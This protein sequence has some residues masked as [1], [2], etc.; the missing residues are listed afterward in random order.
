MRKVLMISVY[1][2]MFL[3]ANVLVSVFGPAITPI[4]ALFLIAG[5]MVLRDRIQ[6]ESGVA[7]S[8]SACVI[9]GLATIAIAPGS[10][11]IAV[12]SALSVMLA[13]SASALAFKLKS[14]GFF[15]KAMPANI[16]AAAVDSL[17]FPLI[18]FGSIMPGV[19]LAQFAAKTIGATIILMI[20][21]R[22]TKR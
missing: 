20:I 19:T 8:I 21:K 3:I 2:T 15:S 6:Y 17:A 1:V 16:S 5:D 18:A 12:A 4:N 22:Y 11:M 14:G 7:W 13:G 10:E 9:A